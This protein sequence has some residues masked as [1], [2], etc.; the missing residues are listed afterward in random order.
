MLTEEIGE[1]TKAVAKS[2]VVMDETMKIRQEEKAKN[3]L[4]IKDAQ[5]A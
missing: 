3:K 5:E 2:N 4:M 1:L